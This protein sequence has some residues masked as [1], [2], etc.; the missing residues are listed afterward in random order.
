MK[1]YKLK[2]IIKMDN[3]SIK[4]NRS[5]NSILELKQPMIIYKVNIKEIFIYNLKEPKIL[6]TISPS[7]IPNTFNVDTTLNITKNEKKYKNFERSEEILEIKKSKTKVKKRIKSKIDLHEEDDNFNDLEINKNNNQTNDKLMLSLMRPARPENK[8]PEITYQSKQIKSIN[9][10]RNINNNLNRIKED[11]NNVEL[12]SPEKIYL[13]S[14]VTIKQ[15]AEISMISPQEI[16]KFLFLKGKLATL[17]D[18]IN[19][20]IALEI[21]EKFGIEIIFKSINNNHLLSKNSYIIDQLDLDQLVDRPPIVT[22]MGHVDHGKTT[23]IDSIR[24][25]R[26]KLVDKEKGGITQ[27]IGAYQ[28]EIL[29]KNELKKITFLD[30]PGH[31]AFIGMRA[32]GVQITDISILVIAADD[33]IKPQTKEAIE[34]LQKKGIPI[35]VAITKIDKPSANIEKLKKDLTN[36]NLISEDWGGNTPIIPVNALTAENID[37]L[38]EVILITAEIYNFK[39]NLNKKAKGTIIESYIDRTQGPIATVLVQN[40]TIKVGDIIVAGDSFGKIRVINDDNNN[41]ILEAGPSSPIKVCGLSKIAPI[42][43][44][45]KICDTEKEAKDMVNIFNISH[46]KDNTLF[47]N[48]SYEYKKQNN[49][50]CL[51]VIV[52]T[53]TQG[54]IEAILYSFSTIPQNLINLQIINISTGEITEN[55]VELAYSSKSWLIGF[56]TTLAPGTKQC[57]EKKSIKISEY[58]I[59]Y[60]LIEDTV[61][62]MEDLLDPNYTEE[63]IGSSEVK[64]IFSLSKGVIAGCYISS[65]KLKKDSWIHIIRNNKIIHKGILESLKK[66][67]E[68]AKEVEAGLECGVFINDF[69]DWAIGDIIKCFNLIKQKKSLIE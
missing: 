49:E 34:Y 4:I 45:F 20:D 53:N 6:E 50:K 24:K 1:K 27:L 9:K 61:Q 40:G 42:G 62:R 56:N 33:G 37:T 30:T 32:R 52:K 2:I 54:S 66:I 25:T 48:I 3:R 26:S 36:Y 7:I 58:N 55:D 11:K 29:Y 16:I 60:N 23:L 28:V 19:K 12:I 38:L 35:I 21:G 31:E 10:N 41:K 15:F 64:N 14:A 65:G 59:I 44:S 67:K 46:S 22:I 47:F 18:I 5:I 17:N 68:D 57:A 8:N 13:E 63:E 51:R 43:E 39:A 69:Q